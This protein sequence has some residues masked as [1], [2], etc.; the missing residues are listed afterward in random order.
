[1][2]IAGMPGERLSHLVQKVS[3]ACLASESVKKSASSTQ[4]HKDTKEDNKLKRTGM[5]PSGPLPCPKSFDSDRLLDAF[6][7]SALLTHLCW[8]SWCLGVLVLDRL[9]VFFHTSSALWV[10]NSFWGSTG[11]KLGAL[12]LWLL[13]PPN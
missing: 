4:R 5:K 1:M 11:R 8:F 3:I 6:S 10:L 7:R 9:E 2:P 12:P 13:R